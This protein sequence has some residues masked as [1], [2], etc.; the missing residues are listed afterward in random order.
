[1]TFNPP[2]TA[3]EI[4]EAYIPAPAASGEISTAGLGEPVK[5]SLAEAD[6]V[7][8]VSGE[9]ISTVGLLPVK[10]SVAQKNSVLSLPPRDLALLTAVPAVL[11]RNVVVWFEIGSSDG[12]EI[13][14]AGNDVKFRHRSKAT[15]R[16]FS[17]EKPGF[18]VPAGELGS[19][20]LWSLTQT[21][22]VGLDLYCNASGITAVPN[23]AFLTAGIPLEACLVGVPESP[24]EFQSFFFE[25]L[26]LFPLTDS[27]ERPQGIAT[28]DERKDLG[29]LDIRTL[30]DV[31]SAV[32]NLVPNDG[33]RPDLEVLELHNGVVYGGAP[34]MAFIC[35]TPSLAGIDLSMTRGQL[36]PAL[37]LLRFLSSRPCQLSRDCEFNIV[38][39][40]RTTLSF[41]VPDLS[42]LGDGPRLLDQQPTVGVVVEAD[43]LSKRLDTLRRGRGANCPDAIL[44]L[45]FGAGHSS[46]KIE[47]RRPSDGRQTVKGSDLS[48]Q[49]DEPGLAFDLLTPLAAAEKALAG[50]VGQINLRADPRHLYVS[51]SLTDAP[52]VVRSVRLPADPAEPPDRLAWQVRGFATRTSNRGRKRQAAP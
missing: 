2:T 15:I 11:G 25:N 6:S 27:V 46:I 7:G 10:P 23:L 19:V 31:V 40:S 45:K 52:S 51:G 24:L 22:S 48:C 28:Q 30:I 50:C 8:S 38:S 43:Q 35:N 3:P 5:P 36:R 47:G 12:I 26:P 42:H 20:A 44:H 18:G 37:R 39:D 16:G 9:M 21:P 29:P 34:E 17:A 41:K 14:A 49:S 13:S 1:M 32:K 4:P 33:K